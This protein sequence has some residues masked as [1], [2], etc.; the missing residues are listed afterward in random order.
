M[1]DVSGVSG[2][3]DSITPRDSSIPGIGMS[4]LSF[5]IVSVTPVVSAGIVSRGVSML[6]IGSA[7][8]PH[9]ASDNVRPAIVAAWPAVT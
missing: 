1:A 2:K 9:A 6:S 8:P 3:S 4:V 5:T 7:V